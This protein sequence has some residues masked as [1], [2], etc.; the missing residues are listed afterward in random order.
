VNKP[1]FR[2][3]GIFDTAKLRRVVE[4]AKL[5]HG[6]FSTNFPFGKYLDELNFLNI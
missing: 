5:L 1:T 6:N 3:A 2:W 4:M